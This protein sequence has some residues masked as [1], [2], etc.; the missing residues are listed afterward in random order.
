ME[1]E[2]KNKRKKVRQEM[3]AIQVWTHAQALRA[4]PYVRSIM[5]SL[6]E[7]RLHFQ[8]CQ[9]RAQRL[10]SR[11]GRPD[12]DRILAQEEASQEAQQAAD[13]F[14]SAFEELLEL[15]VYC[16]DPV[17]GLALIPFAHENQLAWFVFDLFDN[18]PL[19]TW[20][21]HEDPLETRRPIAEVL[22][23]PVPNTLIA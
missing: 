7:H 15:D 22:K 19:R 2:M 20:R 14:N 10:G 3:R 9:L 13:A 16:L 8:E 5:G 17:R 4:L 18:E 6:R 12:R 1:N 21:Y 23:E 11:S